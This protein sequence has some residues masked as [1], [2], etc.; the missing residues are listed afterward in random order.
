MDFKTEKDALNLEMRSW[1]DKAEKKEVTVA[2]AQAKVEELRAKKLDIERLEAL[3][4]KPT[5]T[6]SKATGWTEIKEALMQKR[7]I[8]TNGITSGVMGD[9]VKAYVEGN[10]LGPYITKYA[11]TNGVVSV[12][13]PSIA[14][15]VGAAEGSASGTD[16]TGVLKGKQLVLK[17]YKSTL[18]ISNLALQGTSIE[19][20]LPSIFADAFAGAIDAQVIAGDGTGSNGLG[21][22]T[23]S[24]DGV[25]TSQDF[26]GTAS[27]ASLIALATKVNAGSGA[28]GKKAIVMNYAIYNAILADDTAGYDPFKYELAQQKILGVPIVLAKDAPSA[29]TSGSYIMAGGN[30]A[31]YAM[32]Y[33]G[34]LTIKGI[35]DA[36]SDNIL[37]KAIEYMQ[38]APTVGTSF[39][40]VK[41]A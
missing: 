30:F 32:A 39:F 40:R 14:L 29:T 16:S 26:E 27:M 12:F 37:F 10:K 18:G 3:A 8:T 11:G 5:E 1:L 22:F 2:D 33:S 38:F 23:A 31:H 24:A 17:A 4:D 41:I 35:E 36:D 7:A 21:I 25:P 6:R 34:D 28:N 13:A 15:P 9:M 20:E 19:K